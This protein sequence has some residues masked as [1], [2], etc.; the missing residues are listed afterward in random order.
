MSHCIRGLLAGI[1]LV[2][3]GS[4]A[5]EH[6]PDQLRV[7]SYNIHHG[8]GIDSKL[9]LSRIAEI[10]RSVDPD[11]VMLQ[12]VDQNV[13]RSG[14][15]DQPNRLEELT[16][17]RSIFGANIDLQGGKYGNAILTRLPL[18]KHHNYQ[19]ANY[20]Q[21][22]QRGVLEAELWFFGMPLRVFGTHFDHRPDDRERMASAKAINLISDVSYPPAVLAGDINATRDTNVLKRLQEQW[23]IAGP[24][25]PTIPST[26][27][28]NQIDFIFFRP[29]NHW[30]VLETRV[31]EE[32]L[33]SDHRPILSVLQ[34]VE[35][36][37]ERE[38]R[39]SVRE[40]VLAVR[41][42]DGKVFRAE[43]P[44]QWRDRATA[45]RLGMETVM[46]PMPEP[47]PERAPAFQVLN[48]IDRGNYWLQKISYQS[49]MGCDTPAYLCI[50]K[51]LPTDG[52][53]KVPAVLCLHPTDNQFGH[54]V[55]VGLGG[56]ANRQYA[57]EL[58]ERGYVTLA[59]SYP[60]LANYQPDLEALGWSSGT[61]KAVWDNMR[62]IDLLQSLPYVDDASIGA[63]GHS[64]GGHNAIYTAAHDSRIRAVVSSCGLDRYQDYYDGDPARWLPGEGWTQTRYMPR[65]TNYRG[66][67]MDIPFDF[68]ELLA[69]LAPRHVMI[70]APTHDSNFRVASVQRLTTEARKVFS[71][72]DLPE[73]LTV[74][75]PDCE[76]DFPLEMRQAAYEMFDTAFS[77][78]GRP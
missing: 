64:L 20:D 63:I 31:L 23:S 13:G 62:G 33:A 16:G 22:E 34:W 7:L 70:V 10:I 47:R 21:G 36:D 50:P 76:H 54:D 5:A 1:F 11:V 38:R 28:T 59:P 2:L 4:L 75:H 66:R 18:I 72:H 12:E 45:I 44:S 15:V 65:L 48:Q 19:L 67:L 6:P 71:L 46:G 32:P 78:V 40:D 26:Q 8:E 60:L 43:N 52:S 39:L 58:A 57:S 30:N 56:K 9:D 55:V 51:S 41:N 77:F 61:L 25:L 14:T 42:R 17:L 27:P 29:S 53:V 68:H 37:S 74:L 49:Q 3:A 73:R 35:S 69:L 24:D